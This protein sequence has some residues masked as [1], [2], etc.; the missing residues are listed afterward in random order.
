MTTHGH[1]FESPSVSSQP[2]PSFP[3][4][5]IFGQGIV[6]ASQQVQCWEQL[7][8][9][10]LEPSFPNVEGIISLPASNPLQASS[11]PSG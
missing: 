2:S 5:I 11:L 9:L 7:A 3:D 1:L 10:L 8:T 6:P 4:L